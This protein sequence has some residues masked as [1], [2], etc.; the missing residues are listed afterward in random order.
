MRSNFDVASRN[1]SG[2]AQDSPGRA[3]R[4]R[5]G[6]VTAKATLPSGGTRDPGVPRPATDDEELDADWPCRGDFQTV[7]VLWRDAD[8]VIVAAQKAYAAHLFEDGKASMPPSP[9]A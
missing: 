2:Q 9:G 8:V 6:S 3:K 7:D 5:P 4:A 1:L